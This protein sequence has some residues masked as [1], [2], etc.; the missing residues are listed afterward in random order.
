MPVEAKD[1][2]SNLTRTCFVQ[3]VTSWNKFI[4]LFILFNVA[5]SVWFSPS[6]FNFTYLDFFFPLFFLSR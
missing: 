1:L 4:L 6:V 3:V 5:F 2:G